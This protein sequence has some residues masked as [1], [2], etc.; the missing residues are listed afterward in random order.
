[1]R[2]IYCVQL[3]Y[4]SNQANLGVETVFTNAKIAQAYC[5]DWNSKSIGDIEKIVLV[6]YPNSR[7]VF[8][9]NFWADR[10][11]FISY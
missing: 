10:K 2:K 5:D 1:M 4:K 7:V 3:R 6:F 8:I 9:R 11:G